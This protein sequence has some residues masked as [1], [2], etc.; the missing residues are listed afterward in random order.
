MDIF[1]FFKNKKYDVLKKELFDLKKEMTATYDLNQSLLGF[2]DGNVYHYDINNQN[3][4]ADHYTIYR[5]I[6][7]LATLGAG[8]PVDIYRGDKLTPK[9]STLPGGFDIYQPNPFMSLNELHY[10]ALIYFFYRGEYMVEIKEDPFLHLLPINPQHMTRTIDGINWKYDNGKERRMIPYERLIYIRKINPDGSRGLSPVEVL[11]ADLDNEKSALGY[12]TSFFKNNGQVGGFFYDSEGKARSQ[13]MEPIVK[14]FDALHK[15]TQKAYKT[16]GLPNGIRYEDFK[17]TMREMEFLNSI[18]DI[19]DKFLASLGI[20]KALFGVTDQVNRSVSEEATRMLWVYNLKP[21]M[22]RIQETW[23]R[24]FF[25]RLFP[26]YTYKFDFSEVAELRQS[27][28]AIDTQAKLLKFLGYTSNEINEALKLGMEENDDAALNVR[29]LPNSLIPFSEFMNNDDQKANYDPVRSIRMSDDKV[30]DLLLE[31]FPDKEVEKLKAANSYKNQKYVRK[32]S[33]VKRKS[34]T[35]LAGKLG[36]FFSN[37]LGEIIEIV[38]ET[39]TAADNFNI[40][41]TLSKVMNKIN[42]N[43]TKLTVIA[44][45]IFEETSLEADALA[46]SIIGDAGKATIPAEIIESMTNRITNVSNYSYK[47]IRNQIRAGVEAGDSIE[48]I[49][50][51]VG[52]VY[53]FQSARSRMIAR[54]E[55]LMLVERTT[56]K[57]YVEAGVEK[58]KWLDTADS[59][60]RSS[61]SAN[62]SQGPIPYGQA[63]SNGQMHPGAGG[64]ASEVIGCRCTFVAVVN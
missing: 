35:K 40:N 57:R 43:K 28:E 19:R 51:R 49:A 44:T 25:K 29:T 30:N 36:K 41:I 9:D 24:T 10:I 48:A 17:Q 53:R 8:L 6:D 23:Q 64:I 52:G 1:K 34:E 2:S 31:Y 33:R 38:L 3:M 58:K 16:L 7:M 13:D 5:G 20:H 59:K 54:T 47:L 55:T 26:L 50:K 37:E 60:V 14:Q 56:D 12:S 61:H 27:I 46:R 4:Y 62:A 45:P 22:L 42:E 32:I 18:K 21:N 39:Q 11:R 15:G 63:F